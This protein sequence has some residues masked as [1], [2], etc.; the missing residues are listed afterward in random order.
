MYYN[1]M[2]NKDI[3][4]GA[5]KLQKSNYKSICDKTNTVY[6]TSNHSK[7]AY[8]ASNIL[9]HFEN[10]IHE[11]IEII[12]IVKGRLVYGTETFK[13][14]L[15]DNTLIIT[16][17][18]SFH[19]LTSD[20]GMNYERFVIESCNKSLNK[21]LSLKISNNHLFFNISGNDFLKARFFSFLYY[22]KLK[23]KITHTH[24]EN[25]ILNLIDEILINIS[26]IDSSPITIQKEIYSQVFSNMIAYV[27]DNFST[28]TVKSLA[29]QFHF[30]E[31]Y[32]YTLFKQFIKLSP[33]QYIT[34][35]KLS[36]AHSLIER[37]E[38]MSVAA[39]LCGYNNYSSFFRAYKKF[40]TT[41]PT[42]PPHT[43][44]T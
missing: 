12:Y 17:K 14:T 22:N 42:P 26:L 7:I 40:L 33:Q 24:Y 9:N 31:N 28:V 37:G 19:Y 29:Q 27:K 10:H 16:P 13:Q 11:H 20:D 30:S 38:K 1:K 41:T 8:E 23:E 4:L 34:T 2:H 32:V 25:I 6:V 44:Q 43:Q 21:L 18:R 5:L 3:F 35:I 39:C 15:T 36:H